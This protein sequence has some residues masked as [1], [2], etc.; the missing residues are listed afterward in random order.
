MPSVHVDAL[1]PDQAPSLFDQWA[2]R[3]DSLCVGVRGLSA[4]AAA[5]RLSRG[6]ELARER[7][8]QD[9]G[10]RAWSTYGLVQNVVKQPQ[11]CSV[12]RPVGSPGP[13]GSAPSRPA[14]D[15]AVAACPVEV[16]DPLEVC[17]AWG[18][19]RLRSE[20]CMLGNAVEGGGRSLR[21]LLALCAACFMC[22]CV[23]VLPRFALA[24]SRLVPACVGGVSR[25]RGAVPLALRCF[26]G[27]RACVGSVSRMRGVVP[28]CAVACVRLLCVSA[29]MR[30]VGACMLHVGAGGLPLCAYMHSR[31]GPA[32]FRFVHALTRS[33]ARSLTH[34]LVA[35][36]AGCAVVFKGVPCAACQR[37][38]SVFALRCFLG[39]MPMHT[40]A[41]Q[42]LRRIL[43]VAARR[44]RLLP[45]VAACWRLPRLLL[46]GRCR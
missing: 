46:P 22:F 31:R 11:I 13:T 29:S 2:A 25:M 30:H 38:L 44:R 14:G 37:G 20:C 42:A 3:L 15:A 7:A 28:L 27:A 36:H 17:A 41:V 18:E 5:D 8:A 23:F 43:G 9:P 12:L 19:G 6:R 24:C 21:S 16:G 39:V 33:L 4:A 45:G 34:S 26:L 40:Y 32:C 35:G 1:G 10:I